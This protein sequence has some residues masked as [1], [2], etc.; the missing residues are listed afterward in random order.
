MSATTQVYWRGRPHAEGEAYWRA[1]RSLSIRKARQDA[2][3]QILGEEDK[4][5]KTIQEYRELMGFYQGQIKAYKDVE[6]RLGPPQMIQEVSSKPK[7]EQQGPGSI[8]R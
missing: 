8:N 6:S 3:R 5:A 2:Y 1:K 7:S 4:Q